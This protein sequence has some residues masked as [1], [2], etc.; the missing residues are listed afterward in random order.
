MVSRLVRQADSP[1][2]VA[3]PRFMP[4]MST[5]DKLDTMLRT[6]FE[7]IVKHGRGIRYQWILYRKAEA[8]EKKSL[9]YLMLGIFTTVSI[10]GGLALKTLA[11]IAGKA[12]IASKSLIP[13]RNLY[14]V[15][16]GEVERGRPISILRGIE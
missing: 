15:R 13:R 10:V 9:P 3:E 12:L 8:E 6:R 2:A 16:P 14:V 7:Q 5:E 1:V 11:A 4:G